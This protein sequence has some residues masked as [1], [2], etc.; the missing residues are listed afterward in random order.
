MDGISADSRRATR[1]SRVSTETRP[2]DDRPH[3][4]VAS[5]FARVARS[6]RFERA[7]DVSR[8]STLAAEIGHNDRS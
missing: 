1:D 6:R 2:T 8:R 5:P 4:V 7:D 3:L